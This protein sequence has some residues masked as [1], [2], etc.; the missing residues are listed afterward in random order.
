MTPFHSFTPVSK[1][2]VNSGLGCIKQ[3]YS[4]S[5]LQYWRL[6]VYSERGIAGAS[7]T[8]LLVEESWK[9]KW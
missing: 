4:Y 9:D 7:G 6:A 8:L 3:N 1:L 2:S 5:F